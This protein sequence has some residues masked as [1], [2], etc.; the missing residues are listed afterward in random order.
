MIRTE[1]KKTY[2][3]TELISEVIC[4]ICG[5]DLTQEDEKIV[6]VGLRDRYFNED[7]Q[8]LGDYETGLRKELCE[9]CGKHVYE[10]LGG[11]LEVYV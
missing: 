5:K 3:E 11:G 7:S 9:E 4:D 8:Y 10:Y 2:Y 1:K 6:V